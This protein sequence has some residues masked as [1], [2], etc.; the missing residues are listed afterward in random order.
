MLKLVDVQNTE[1]SVVYGKKYLDLFILNWN[2]EMY[3]DI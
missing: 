1:H 2:C 3:S